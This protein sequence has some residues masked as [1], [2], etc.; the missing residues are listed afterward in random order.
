MKVFL[1]IIFCLPNLLLGQSDSTSQ[2]S[3]FE[4][5]PKDSIALFKVNMKNKSLYED[6]LK[7]SN[8]HQIRFAFV[9]GPVVDPLGHAGVAVLP[10]FA[11]KINP[12][13]NVS[14]PSSTSA[15]VYFSTSGSYNFGLQQSLF[16]KKDNWRFRMYVNWSRYY[17]NF[18]GFNVQPSEITSQTEPALIVNDQN[19]LTLE[20]YRRVYKR[21]YAGMKSVVENNNVYGASEVDQL[22]LDTSNVI[23]GAH[24][25]TTISPTVFWDDRDNIYWSTKGIYALV[26]FT[27]AYSLVTE[28]NN[29]RTFNWFVNHYQTLKNAHKKIILATRIAGIHNDGEIPFSKHAFYGQYIDLRGYRTGMYVNRSLMALQSELR[30]DVWRYI[31]VAGFVGIGKSFYDFSKLKESEWLPAAGIGLYVKL[32][33]EYNIRANGFVAVGK[34][35]WNWYLSLIQSF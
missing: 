13:D 18:Y 32:I 29:Y 34:N 26:S 16:L 19:S 10:V 9:P 24:Q 3:K 11:Y 28:N 6:S 8:K 5:T 25:Y 14:P 35:N 31:N 2:Y 12:N 22:M 27:S 23:R 33:K 4:F 30:M 15:L 1:V 21:L 20:A 7:F 17:Y